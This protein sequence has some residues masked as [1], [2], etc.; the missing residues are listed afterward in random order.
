MRVG[1]LR[2]CVHCLA[3]HFWDGKFLVYVKILHIGKSA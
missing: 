3:L 1:N 2:D